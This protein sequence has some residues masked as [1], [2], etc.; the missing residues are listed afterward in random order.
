[1]TCGTVG[2][3]KLAKVKG[4]LD[5]LRPLLDRL[6]DNNFRIAQKLYYRKEYGI[7]IDSKLNKGTTVIIVIPKEL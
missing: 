6:I 1:L 7:K 4:Y 3:L 5:Q 2:I